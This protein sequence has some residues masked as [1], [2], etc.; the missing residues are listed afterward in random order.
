MTKCLTCENAIYDSLWGEVICRISQCRIQCQVK[1]CVN[2]EE[3]DPEMSLRNKDYDYK[4][5]GIEETE[6]D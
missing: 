1:D 2:Y 4:L 6:N 5:Y 3:G